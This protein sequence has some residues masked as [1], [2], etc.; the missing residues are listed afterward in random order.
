MK[1]LFPIILLFILMASC[2]P[3][4]QIDKNAIPKDLT[5]KKAFLKAKKA[6]LRQLNQ[7]IAK[8]EREI[9]AL[10]PDEQKVKTAVTTMPITIKDFDRYIGIQASVQSDDV[11]SV[12]SEVGGRI[13]RLRVKE[14]DLVRK[15]QLIAKI[16]LEQIDK[17]IAELET[18]LQL[19]KDIFERQERLWK[20][21]I[22]SELQYLEA[23]NTKERL[24]KSL[25]T[26]A[27][28]KQKANVYAPIS[29][30]IDQEFAKQGE[31]AS[32]G[33]PIVQILNTNK[34]KVVADV[35]EA[36]LG[37]VRKGEIVTIQFP[38]IDKEVQGKISQLGRVIDPA[39]RTFKVEVNM[40]NKNGLLKPNLL[41]SM[42]INDFSANN[43][44]TIP[45]ELIQQEISGKD[46]VFIKEKGEKGVFATKVYV[47]PGESYDGEII[48]N[49]GLNGDEE[50]VVKG[51]RNLVDKQLIKVIG[52]N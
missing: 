39:N 47:E 20:Q 9:E 7:V 28:Q 10:I 2:Q 25:E 31:M 17:Q 42:F 29:G 8:V 44:V 24:E 43:V 13:V 33:M 6:E 41:A 4:Q 37:K 12:S 22:G 18:S 1:H 50:L 21:N 35:P 46:F 36:Y 51:S 23:K 34:V 27:F 32:P 45:L 40:S 19:A 5:G 14:G 15:G 48:I 3:E 11:V 16:D 38:A 49:E 26:I 30:V 52:S